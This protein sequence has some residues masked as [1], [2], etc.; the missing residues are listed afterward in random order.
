M[1]MSG[2]SVVLIDGDL[3]HRGAT[4]FVEPNANA[5][6][7]EVLEGK[8]AVSDALVFDQQ[9]GGWLL[10]IAGD[11]TE[12]VDLFS[13]PAM[14]TLLEDLRNRFS[15]IL[16][17]TPAA[18]AVSDA[19][20]LASKADGVLY[21]AQ[22]ASTPSKAIELGLAALAS[23]GSNIIGLA[24]SKVDLKR[25]ARTSYNDGAY[26]QREYQGYYKN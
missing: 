20:I 6:L 24:L 17:D 21:I 3:R 1:A 8:V 14:D 11:Q 10:P 4:A 5:G 23:S 16:I 12:T 18:L 25:L 22:W 9:S 19:R 2:T 26:Y 15:V 7:V 13:S